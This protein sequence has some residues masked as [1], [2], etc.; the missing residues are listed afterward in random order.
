[1]AIDCDGTL[2]FENGKHEFYQ[3]GIS[4]CNGILGDAGRPANPPGKP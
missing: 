4:L 1:M 2:N 3:T